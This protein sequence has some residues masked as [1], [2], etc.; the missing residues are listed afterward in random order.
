MDPTVVGAVIGFTVLAV[1]CG[2]SAISSWQTRQ[3]ML[4]VFGENPGRA[5]LGQR[6][7]YVRPPDLPPQP[8]P[9]AVPPPAASGSSRAGTPGTSP[10]PAPSSSR[11]GALAPAEDGASGGKRTR[12]PFKPPSLAPPPNYAEQA[13]RPA[14]DAED[15]EST[16]GNSGTPAPA[17][18]AARATVRPPALS[19][20]APELC[21][22]APDTTRKPG[23]APISRER[24]AVTTRPDLATLAR[25]LDVA[26]QAQADQAL[27]PTRIPT[28]RPPPRNQQAPVASVVHVAVAPPASA[29][30]WAPAP[31]II[32]AGLG[33]RPDGRREARSERPPPHKP[34][35]PA[36]KPTLLGIPPPTTVR[37]PMTAAPISPRPLPAVVPPPPRAP[38]PSSPSTG[39]TLAP[40]ALSPS[41]DDLDSEDEATR[42]GPRPSPE[43]LGL[44]PDAQGALPRRRIYA[45]L[46]S[47]P[48][49]V[50]VSGRR[51]P[52]VRVIE[53]A[54]TD[55]DEQRASRESADAT[56]AAV[57]Q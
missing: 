24:P 52:T 26:D 42:V 44:A 41:D 12:E 17:A 48:S 54:A 30:V 46:A 11:A 45:T 40:V 4:A 25:D 36:R 34:P 33:E 23:A 57:T 22:G 13:R 49:A 2:F 3:L 31:G 9:P 15:V 20:E 35:Q 14:P 6:G 47:M 19:R 1:V 51:A 16:P 43:A 50:P 5:Q 8:A 39:G 37:P 28:M 38:E 7:W 55:D 18:P 21:R 10:E 27:E 53:A 56:V 32:A 29:P